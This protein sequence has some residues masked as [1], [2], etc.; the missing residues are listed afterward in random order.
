[1]NQQGEVVL[2]PDPVVFY[3]EPLM[4]CMSQN[5]KNECTFLFKSN[6][7]DVI[8]Q[9]ALLFGP[10]N[11]HQ[12]SS[13]DKNNNTT[14]EDCHLP[15]PESCNITRTD[16]S[17]LKNITDDQ[18]DFVDVN[19]LTFLHNDPGKT[20]V[21]ESIVVSDDE[22][23]VIFVKEYKRTDTRLS[24]CN[25]SSPIDDGIR[26]NPVRKAR[27]LKSTRHL[28]HE[29]LLEEDF[30]VLDQ[31]DEDNLVLLKNKLPASCATSSNAIY[32][33]WPINAY[34]RPEF[35]PRTRKIEPFDLSIRQ[36]KNQQEK[37]KCYLETVPKPKKKPK[38]KYFI[39]KRRMIKPEKKVAVIELKET[40]ATTFD[41]VCDFFKANLED[42][43]KER[44][45]F[46]NKGLYDLCKFQTSLFSLVNDFGEDEIRQCLG[47]ILHESS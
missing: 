7:N 31:F 25:R 18:P 20:D 6:N 29:H 1:M 8:P 24:S 12:P 11:Y 36:I 32:K 10:N 13:Q 22:N 34:E 46:F 19:N 33:E 44:S 41:L 42:N 14:D 30:D 28:H 5:M 21:E 37:K 17:E 38:K 39:R 16:I 35:D 23:D 26:R 27:S 40:I 9:R 15:F 47:N 4:L 43:T 3:N 45:A 2:K